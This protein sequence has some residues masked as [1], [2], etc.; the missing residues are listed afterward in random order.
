ML[1]DRVSILL[2][3]FLRK[4]GMAKIGLEFILKGQSEY[5]FSSFPVVMQ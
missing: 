3:K 4:L 5:F 2:T 1:G